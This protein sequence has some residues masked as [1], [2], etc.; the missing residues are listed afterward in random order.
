MPGSR[1]NPLTV[2]HSARSD[3]ASAQN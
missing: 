3:G 1:S 2:I